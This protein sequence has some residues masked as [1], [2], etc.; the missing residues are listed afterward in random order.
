[1]YLFKLLYHV[2]VSII[3]FFFYHGALFLHYFNSQLS[4]NER[5]SNNAKIELII[6]IMKLDIYGKNYRTLIE[7]NLDHLCFQYHP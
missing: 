2:I 6:S 1:M 3:W 4:Y 5:E 7:H